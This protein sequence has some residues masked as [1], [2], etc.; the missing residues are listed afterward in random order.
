MPAG[1]AQASE[2]HPI[3][4]QRLQPLPQPFEFGLVGQAGGGSAAV[5][6]A[7]SVHVFDLDGGQSFAPGRI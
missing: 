7:S 2:R 5:R 1:S 6:A 4:R 3:D